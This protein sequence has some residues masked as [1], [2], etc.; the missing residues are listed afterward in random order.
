MEPKSSVP[1]PKQP[2]TGPY[3]ETNISSPYLPLYFQNIQPN[4]MLPSM[5][6][7]FTND[8]SFLSQ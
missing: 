5:I 4:I 1:F 3:P 7:S 8:L 2:A 6:R